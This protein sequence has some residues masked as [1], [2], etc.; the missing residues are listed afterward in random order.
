MNS[1]L[2]VGNTNIYQRQHLGCAKRIPQPLLCQQA[3]RIAVAR[4][5]SRH[6]ET[7][8]GGVMLCL[9]RSAG[10]LLSR[11]ST[12][13]LAA[14]W[15]SQAGAQSSQVLDP[16]TVVASKTEETVIQALAGVSAVRQDRIDQLQP[17][18]TSDVFW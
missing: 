6:N 11:V 18:R 10:A 3:P 17:T 14:L 15:A 5:P 13:T 9:R 4:Q 12:I 8:C 16:I 7:A 1:I 2:D